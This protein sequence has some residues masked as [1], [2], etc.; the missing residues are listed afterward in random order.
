[1]LHSDF[2]PGRS[3]IVLQWFHESL[4]HLRRKVLLKVAFWIHGSSRFNCSTLTICTTQA[5]AAGQEL[6]ICYG[7]QVGE[8]PTPVRQ[9]MLQQQYNFTCTCD[10]CTAWEDPSAAGGGSVRERECAAAGLRCLAQK[11]CPG[12]SWVTAS[13]RVGVTRVMRWVAKNEGARGALLFV[14][15]TTWA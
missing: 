8:M 11:T 2:V 4:R 5:V 13:D 14:V 15:L 7:P 10:T 6:T 1:M 3:Q 9:H 12:E